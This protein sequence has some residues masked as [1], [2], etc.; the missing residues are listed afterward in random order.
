MGVGVM[1]TTGAAAWSSIAMSTP[2]PPKAPGELAGRSVGA[3]AERAAGELQDDAHLERLA[4]DEVHDGGQELVE[5]AGFTR[6]VRW[7]A[8]FRRPERPESMGA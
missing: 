1:T 8:A 7:P 5:G 2:L 6:S 4:D 3:N